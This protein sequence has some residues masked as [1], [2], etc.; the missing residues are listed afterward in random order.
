MSHA[1]QG[2]GSERH[3]VVSK[4]GPASRNDS[5]KKKPPGTVADEKSNESQSKLPIKM[6]H[7]AQ[8]QSDQTSQKSHDQKHQSEN[9]ETEPHLQEPPAVN[10]S[11]N[12]SEVSDP[13]VRVCEGCG[14]SLPKANY[15]LHI[16]RCDKN[17]PASS[18]AVPKSAKNKK[19]K[20]KAAS[21]GEKLNAELAED[22][23]NF[24]ELVNE[25][26]EDNSKCHFPKCKNNAAT[27]G[28]NCPFCRKRFCLTHFIAEAHGCG[29]KAKEQAR[30]QISRDGVLHRGS[31]VPD[32]KP[33]A[34]KRA[35]L[36]RKLEAKIT[37]M[38][39][40]R[41]NKKKTK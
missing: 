27:L 9:L 5:K 17:S 21:K 20:A 7:G 26:I 14:K 12:K 4:I 1:S 2:E 11:D 8:N 16:L 25:A 32:K 24:D 34:S 15:D 19:K 38:T 13:H 28:Q 37:E 36:E 30:A 31:G 10:D 39:E 23:E 6:S 41:K 40:K 18:G 22:I 29:D 35:H 3:I 33:S